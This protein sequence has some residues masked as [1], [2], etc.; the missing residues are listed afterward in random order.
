MVNQRKSK[1]MLEQAL[2]KHSAGLLDEAELLY[3]K[4][5][6]GAPHDTEALSLLGTLHMQRKDYKAG[7]GI[8]EKSLAINP[9]QAGAL[10]NLGIALHETQQYQQALA[11]FDKAIKLVLLSFVQCNAKVI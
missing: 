6:K 7:L 5:L 11:S 2:S 4:V 9:N 10:N 3:K 1:V 8:L